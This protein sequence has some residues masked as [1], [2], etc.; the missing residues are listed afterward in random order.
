MRRSLSIGVAVSMV[1]A[2]ALAM[3]SARARAADED[4]KDERRHVELI[5]ST[6]REN[7]A[8]ARAMVAELTPTALHGDSLPAA[9]QRQCDRLS[10][11]SGIAATMRVDGDVPALGMAP[12][13]V[14]LRATQEA[15]RGRVP[16]PG[17]GAGDCDQRC[18]AEHHV[19]PAEPCSSRNGR[20]RHRDPPF[21]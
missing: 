11:E 1:S 5:R 20:V 13:V 21:I 18:R 15:L 14:L 16:A 3:V 19:S 2:T 4:E 7:L 6:A 17:P 12:D 9:I 10:D 8:E